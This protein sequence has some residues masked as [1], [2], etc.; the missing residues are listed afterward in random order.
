MMDKNPDFP[1]RLQNLLTDFTCLLANCHV[2]CEFFFFSTVAFS[3]SLSHKAVTSEAPGTT[4]VSPIRGSES[5][6]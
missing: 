5:K 3:V 1:L 6:I 4:T 2:M